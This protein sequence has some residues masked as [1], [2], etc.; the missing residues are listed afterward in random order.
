[1]QNSRPQPSTSVL[2]IAPSARQLLPAGPPQSLPRGPLSNGTTLLPRR[3]AHSTAACE[4]CRKRKVKVLALF[5]NVSGICEL[6]GGFSVQCGAAGVRLLRLSLHQLRLHHELR[7]RD[8]CTGTQEEAVRD[9]Q[10]EHYLQRDLSP[11]ASTARVRSGRDCETYQER[12]GARSHFAVHQGGRLAFAIGPD[13]RNTV[14]LCVP[15]G[16]G[17]ASLPSSTRQSVSE[18]S[19]VRM[20]GEWCPDTSRACSVK[21]VS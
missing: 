14:S 6:T 15:F 19:S 8:P 17:D 12:N 2:S 7:N 21:S 16:S 11:F 1:M 10:P 20:G 3:K 9:G 18:R 13:A 5:P 4:T